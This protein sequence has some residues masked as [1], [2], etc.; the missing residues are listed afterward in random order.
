MLLSSGS[1]N[2]L[3][4]LAISW[5][6]GEELDALAMNLKLSNTDCM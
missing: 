4:R 2:E 1:G 5:H 3:G 6:R